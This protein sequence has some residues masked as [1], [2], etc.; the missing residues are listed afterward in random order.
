MDYYYFKEW[1]WIN[2]TFEQYCN[3][4][5]L[6]NK[7]LRELCDKEN[8]I[9]VPFAENVPA[10]TKYFGDICHLRQ[11]GIMLKAQVMAETLIPIIEN[12]LTKTGGSKDSV[13]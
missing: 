13:N 9:Y 2:S 5:K 4:M 12:I 10:S 11:K 6:W 8:L 1:G 7:K 3:I